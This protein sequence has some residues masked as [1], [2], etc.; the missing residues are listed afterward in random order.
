MDP[1]LRGKPV[2]DDDFG[3]GSGLTLRGSAL[4][5]RLLC[6][7]KGLSFRQTFRAIWLGEA[8]SIGVMELVMNAVDYMVGGVQAASLSSPIFYIG[9]G[10]AIPAGFITG[11]PANYWLL[12][13]EIKGKCH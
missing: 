1:R 9:L 12:R 6:G 2:A 4:L 5:C 10:I 3:D 11:W 7:A 13:N 8:I